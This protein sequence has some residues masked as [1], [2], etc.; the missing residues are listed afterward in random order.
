MKDFALAVRHVF[1]EPASGPA[2]IAQARERIA[3]RVEGRFRGTVRL[4]TLTEGGLWTRLV[5]AHEPEAGNVI[6]TGAHAHRYRFR[7]VS[8]GNGRAYTTIE[9]Q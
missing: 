4:E 1:S 5:D 9:V 6:A 7:C 2:I 3:Y 8:L